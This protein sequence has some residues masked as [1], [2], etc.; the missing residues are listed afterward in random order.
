MECK[1]KITNH[2]RKYFT[3]RLTRGYFLKE[4]VVFGDAKEMRHK[5]SA[6]EVK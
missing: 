4:N 1:Y 2:K 6:V 3:E 5:L